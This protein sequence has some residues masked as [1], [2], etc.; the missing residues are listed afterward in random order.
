MG[1]IAYTE[2]NDEHEQA[3]SFTREMS[4]QIPARNYAKESNN[5][6]ANFNACFVLLLYIRLKKMWNGNPSIRIIRRF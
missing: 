4:Y 5:Q 1:I 3:Q 2:F 6:R